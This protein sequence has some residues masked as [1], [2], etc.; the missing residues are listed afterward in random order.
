[1]GIITTS[2]I[3]PST[4][5]ILSCVV[6]SVCFSSSFLRTP[7][8]TAAVHLTGRLPRFHL[9]HTHFTR[10]AFYIL[11]FLFTSFCRSAFSPILHFSPPDIFTSRFLSLLVCSSV[12]QFFVSSDPFCYNSRPARR[13]AAALPG[14][15]RVEAGSIRH[16]RP[17]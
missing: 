9:C 8:S 6:C 13:S 4:Q 7:S 17:N 11:H 16:R 1:M 2:S 3:R 14:Q 12:L 15:H 5:H 10:F